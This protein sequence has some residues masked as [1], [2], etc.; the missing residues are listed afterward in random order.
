MTLDEFLRIGEHLTLGSHLFTAEEIK[1]FAV[2]FDPQPF[3]V[4]EEAARNSVFGALCASG[5]HTASMWM[6]YNLKGRSLLPRWEGPGPEPEFGPSPGF[7]NLKWLK[8]VYAG[9]T[10]T[11]GR[12]TLRHRGL[13]SRPGWRLVNM[14]CDASDAGGA[15][16]LEFESSVLLNTHTVA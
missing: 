15:R 11:F 7:E 5:W 6:R 13:A 14:L 12:T 1:R 10:I 8:P 3:H 9:E 4:D 2:R 16:V